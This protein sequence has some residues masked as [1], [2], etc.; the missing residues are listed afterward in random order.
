[1]TILVYHMFQNPLHR[2]FGWA[3]FMYVFSCS[4][5]TFTNACV[6][7]KYLMPIIRLLN[8]VFWIVLK[9]LW[10]VLLASQKSWQEQLRARCKRRIGSS[11]LITTTKSGKLIMIKIRQYIAERANR[12]LLIVITQTRP[13]LTIFSLLRHRWYIFPSQSSYFINRL[14]FMNRCLWDKSEVRIR[15]YWFFWTSTA[16][17]YVSSKKRSRKVLAALYKP[18][19]I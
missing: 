18:R 16:G 2:V 14:N 4:L 13:G 6:T 5:K 9:C 15:N 10:T 19:R 7:D 11:R 12:I 17:S 8:K 3:L 1:M